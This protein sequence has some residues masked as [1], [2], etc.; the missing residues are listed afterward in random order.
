MPIS[1]NVNLKFNISRYTNN[2]IKRNPSLISVLTA[3]EAAPDTWVVVNVI[4][5]I[6]CP[7]WFPSKYYLG[8]SCNFLN[9]SSLKSWTIPKPTFDIM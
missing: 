2:P 9:N 1:N 6:S 7:D 5:L 8:R 4:L 3:L